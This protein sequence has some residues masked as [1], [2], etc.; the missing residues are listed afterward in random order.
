[1]SESILFLTVFFGIGLLMI[2]A[3][4]LVIYRKVREVLGRRASDWEPVTDEDMVTLLSAA[5]T[6]AG[7]RFEGA[8]TKDGL[9]VAVFRKASR[10]PDPELRHSTNRRI[11]ILDAPTGH[12]GV[13]N[14]RDGGML[15]SMLTSAAGVEAGGP[16][17]EWAIVAG[18]VP[19]KWQ[20]DERGTAL[21]EATRPGEQ[22]HLLEDR[23]ALSLPE[24]S[25]LD[26]MAS[27]QERAAKVRVAIA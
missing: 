9:H 22:L 15:E 12:R 14:H 21:R 1:M 5:P 13:I 27:A 25:L 16:G 18:P 6:L 23:V 24:G 7:G 4:G 19:P 2:F 26:L 8:C 3:I 10:G 17:W 20:N 11:L